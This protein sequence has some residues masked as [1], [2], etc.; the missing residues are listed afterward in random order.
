MGES[1]QKAIKDV[2]RKER[3]NR[4]L[5]LFQLIQ[6][7]LNGEVDSSETPLAEMFNRG[8][9]RKEFVAPRDRG[10]FNY[11]YMDRGEFPMAGT[12]FYGES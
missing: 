11:G 8:G 2:T 12:P 6:S 5:K 9:P 4:R 7:I 1:L 10:T 3:S